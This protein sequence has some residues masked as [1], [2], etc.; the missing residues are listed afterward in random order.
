MVSSVTTQPRPSPLPSLQVKKS[1]S[2]STKSTSAA[3]PVPMKTQTALK[4]DLPT[5]TVA[6]AVSFATPENSPFM[7]TTKQNINDLNHHSNCD[8]PKAS[9]RPAVGNS[10]G[11]T[12]GMVT[13]VTPQE[14]SVKFEINLK[15]KIN[16]VP[17]SSSESSPNTMSQNHPLA[18]SDIGSISNS[19]SNRGNSRNDGDLYGLQVNAN[20]N[21]DCVEQE[22][23]LLQNQ[24]Q[25]GILN[26][27][28]SAAPIHHRQ[29]HPQQ[30][31]IKT[32]NVSTN[33]NY[34]TSSVSRRGGK[35][36]SSYHPSPG[37]LVSNSPSRNSPS[38][39]ERMSTNALPSSS[40]FCS[41]GHDTV[42]KSQDLVSP[43][44]CQSQQQ[45]EKQ[46]Q[47]Q[48]PLQAPSSFTGGTNTLSSVT[49][50][51]PSRIPSLQPRKLSESIHVSST[52]SDAGSVPPSLCSSASSPEND[53]KDEVKVQHQQQH[54]RRTVSESTV[55]VKSETNDEGN[56]GMNTNHG[57][58]QNNEKAI[59]SNDDHVFGDVGNSSISNI[60]NMKNRNN[61]SP[62]PPNNNSSRLQ[63]Q[64]P[65]ARTPVRSPTSSKNPNLSV[66]IAPFGSPGIF[67]SPY[68]PSPPDS[69]K[70]SG[71][72]KSTTPTNFAKDFGKTD[73]TS[74]SF[75]ANN[76]M[77]LI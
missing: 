18:P 71:G 51:S 61:A 65:Q 44:E 21:Q 33:S 40:L 46:Q 22:P 38:S 11:R 36:Q 32:E 35:V 42:I 12:G 24:K 64:Q 1:T 54:L 28:L 48:S 41:S 10:G 60:Q 4:D 57:E 3:S 59:K 31:A 7:S 50:S 14:K 17:S 47:Q 73:L 8:N 75:D 29:Q 76:G 74:S 53:G 70:V 45:L 39:V 25:H 2:S 13:S 15:R 43:K 37:R 27:P 77:F 66:D 16:E 72:Q 67:L 34:Y 5:A 6:T 55:N 19:R 30:L 20:T 69:R 63:Q 26:A 9:T 52:C 56:M 23:R 49:A 68:L 58:N 62:V